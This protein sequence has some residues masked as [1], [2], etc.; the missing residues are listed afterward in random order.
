MNFT[1]EK[2]TI[3][4]SSIRFLDPEFTNADVAFLE[5]RGYVADAKY[6]VV[7]TNTDSSRKTGG[8]S[9]RMLS[10]ITT[11]TF[12]VAFGLDSD[13]SVQ[14]ICAGKP[15]LY[16]GNDLVAT[17]AMSPLVSRKPLFVFAHANI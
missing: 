17:T 1:G 13:V 15:S 12:F 5:R 6:A 2:F 16:F 3:E 9:K 7:D 14:F 11:S 4:G 8:N 10:S